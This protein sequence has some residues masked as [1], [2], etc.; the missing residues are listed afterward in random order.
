MI[1]C[2]KMHFLLGFGLFLNCELMYTYVYVISPIRDAFLLQKKIRFF[3]KM[4]YHDF[5]ACSVWCE[6]NAVLRQNLADNAFSVTAL[7]EVL[8]F[9][10]LTL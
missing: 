4:S 9:V 1:F 6:Q 3:K 7:S 2:W 5:Q 10:W 8:L